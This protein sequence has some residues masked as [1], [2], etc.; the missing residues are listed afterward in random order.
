MDLFAAAA[1]NKSQP[2]SL[3]YVNAATMINLN[4]GPDFVNQTVTTIGGKGTSGGA[5]AVVLPCGMRWIGVLTVMVALV[6]SL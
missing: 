6:T 1:S 4:C 5:P 2:V 3:D